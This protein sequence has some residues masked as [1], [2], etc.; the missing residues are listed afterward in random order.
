MKG[1]MRW[2]SGDRGR[3]QGFLQDRI[4]LQ[5]KWIEEGI[6]L[7]AGDSGIWPVIAGIGGREGELWITGE[8]NMEEEELRRFLI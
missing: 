3:G 1:Q 4:P 8:W 5:W 2:L 7:L 6:A